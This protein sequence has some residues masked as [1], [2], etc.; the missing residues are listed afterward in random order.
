[1]EKLRKN[2]LGLTFSSFNSLPPV[3]QTTEKYLMENI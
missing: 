3:I 1:M 2:Y